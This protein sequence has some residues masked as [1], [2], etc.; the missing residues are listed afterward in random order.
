MQ[1]TTGRHA[2]AAATI[3]IPDVPWSRD[4][5]TRAD[6]PP[7]RTRYTPR[8]SHPARSI[9]QTSA[10]AANPPERAC[11]LTPFERHYLD[12]GNEPGPDEVISAHAAILPPQG[13][14]TDSDRQDAPRPF[15]RVRH[16]DDP[17]YADSRMHAGSHHPRTNS[18][19]VA[20]IDVLPPPQGA[21]SGGVGTFW[22]LDRSKHIEVPVPSQGL[23]R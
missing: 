15:S 1:R 17:A 5:W 10:H 6:A 16:C 11:P 2:T 23:Q 21:R 20:R 19:S 18:Q 8:V 4:S 22:P 3:A 12:T 14:L 13:A 7:H 9:A